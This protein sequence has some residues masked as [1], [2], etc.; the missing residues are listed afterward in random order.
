V[1]LDSSDSP[2]VI[3]LGNPDELPQDGRLSFFLKTRVPETFPPAERVEVATQDESFHVLL[4]E[5][6]GNLT[7]QDAKT[8]FAMLDPMK[9]LGPSAFGPLKFR[10]VSA[11]GVEGNWQPLANLVRV[12]DL[13]EVRCTPVPAKSAERSSLPEKRSAREEKS[14]PETNSKS[15]KN[16]AS[17]SS[18]VSQNAT[19]RSSDPEKS[20]VAEGASSPEKPTADKDCTLSGDKLFLIDAVSA[21]PDFTSSITV[22]DGFVEAALAI[23]EPKG[24]MLYLKLRDDPATVDTAV[25]P[26][27]NA[28]P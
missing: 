23:P 14:A 25:V 8:V 28:Q 21:D 12:P 15:E 5:K 17:E 19:E 13:K 9:L 16:A 1:Q 26:I 22:P 24:K 18:L 3:Q 27:L 4:S 2:H 20:T 10:A 6:D 11:D 7:P